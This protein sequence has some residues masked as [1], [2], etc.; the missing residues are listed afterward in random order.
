MKPL[1]VKRHGKTASAGPGPA[2]PLIRFAVSGGGVGVLS[3]LAVPLLATTLPWALSNAIVTTL[4]TLLCTELH[5]RFTFATGRAAGRR[6]HWQC[7]ASATAA[8]LATGTA[9]HLLH[10][11][12]PSAGLLTEQAVYLAASGLAGTGR[13]LLL[14]HYVFTSHP[15]PST[16]PS[17]RQG[18]AAPPAPATAPA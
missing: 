12:Q 9:V 1:L 2:A 17:T 8:Y 6:E 13:F 5:A 10:L 3:S 7:T 16:Q 11:V 4:S 18:T 14:R 15:A